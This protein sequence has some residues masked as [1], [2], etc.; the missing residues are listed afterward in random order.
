M[1]TVKKSCKKLNKLHSPITGDVSLLF[2]RSHIE[3][4]RG[5]VCTAFCTIQTTCT[6]NTGVTATVPLVY[7]IWKYTRLCLCLLYILQSHKTLS[8]VDIFNILAIFINH[9][10]PNLCFFRFY[11]NFNK[12]IFVPTTTI[13]L[14][15]F[16]KSVC[17]G[18]WVKCT[19]WAIGAA[20]YVCLT[21]TEN[22]W[23]NLWCI[24]WTSDQIRE[25]F[26]LCKLL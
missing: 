14:E 4:N 21:P 23:T 19:L 22:D 18:F 9:I 5:S 26:M 7:W 15:M 24:N 2:W 25:S 17:C 1:Q 13:C 12:N 20:F 10:T 11:N 6:A 16:T 3:V 8:F